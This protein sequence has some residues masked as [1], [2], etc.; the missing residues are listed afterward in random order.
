MKAF[1]PVTKTKLRYGEDEICK[2]MCIQPSEKFSWNTSSLIAGCYSETNT[3][4]PVNHGQFFRVL[5]RMSDVS[6]VSANFKFPAH[7][8]QGEH[9]S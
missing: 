9:R 3:V 1:K 5:T 7:K 6:F 8:Q 4:S 2:V